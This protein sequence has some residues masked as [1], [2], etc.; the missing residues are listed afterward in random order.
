VTHR[1]VVSWRVLRKALQAKGVEIGSRGSEAKLQRRN[2]DGS[3]ET[4]ILQ[5]ECCRSPNSVVWATHLR[6][7]AGKFGLTDDDLS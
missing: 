4:Y 1:R 2:P 3:V 6:R 7:I 5:H